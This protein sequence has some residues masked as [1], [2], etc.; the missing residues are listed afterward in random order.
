MKPWM[1]PWA[2]HLAG[3]DQ[4]IV[5]D[6]AGELTW[7]GDLVEAG[8]DEDTAENDPESPV[9]GGMPQRAQGAAPCFVG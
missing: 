8:V 1:I 6:D 9:H 7:V 3:A 2:H 5:V 4:P